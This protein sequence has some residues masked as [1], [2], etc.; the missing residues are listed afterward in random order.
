MHLEVVESY[1]RGARRNTKQ[2]TIC[3]VHTHRAYTE[4]KVED[5]SW[6]THFNPQQE[7]N[8]WGQIRTP[9]D[10]GVETKGGLELLPSS[11]LE[12]EAGGWQFH[13]LWWV[14]N[15]QTSPA[16]CVSHSLSFSPAPHPWIPG[17]CQN[18]VESHWPL[19]KLV[20]LPGPQF[21]IYK[22]GLPWAQPTSQ[23]R[24]GEWR[25]FVYYKVLR[26]YRWLNIHSTSV[27]NS[28]KL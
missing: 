5:K 19:T 2:K 9:W 10:I 3:H 20:T 25:Q 7:R 23:N 28:P 17:Q 22:M 27:H 8:N 1:S 12:W 6:A 14:S 15:V 4:M 21:G 18:H 26:G 16:L 24:E 11:D 13:P